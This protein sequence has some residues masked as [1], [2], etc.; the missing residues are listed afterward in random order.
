MLGSLQLKMTAE[1]RQNLGIDEPNHGL[2]SNIHTICAFCEL[3]HEQFGRK[4]NQKQ[5]GISFQVY[6]STSLRLMVH[7]EHHRPTSFS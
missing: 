4:E 6:L 5:I 7:S 1:L 3:T 2:K